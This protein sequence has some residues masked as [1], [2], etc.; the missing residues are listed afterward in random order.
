M[1]IGIIVQA[2]MGST[3]L[4][5]KVLKKV[6]DKTILNHVIQRLKQCK[7]ADEIIVA[8]TVLNRDDA[9]EKEAIL[10]GARV[11]RGSESDV[12]ERYYMAAKANALDAVIRVTSDCPLIDPQILDEMISYYTKHEFEIVTNVGNEISNRTYPR[13]LDVEIFSFKS[14]EKAYYHADEDYHREHVT[15][16]LYEETEKVYFFKN[17]V[18]YSN[19]RWTVDTEE[20][21]YL[22]TKIYDALY[23]G[24]HN[25]YL[26][27]II[28]LFER[29]PELNA[30]NA[31]IEQ[32][33]IK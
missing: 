1:K 22:I 5:G 32:K 33:K 17:P 26:K 9:I 31:H 28:S 21:F 27:D 2:R 18:D 8:T 3:R 7:N 6:G 30:I 24:E 12:L 14:L 20:D 4:S 11:F 16:Y 25:F 29:Q 15:P 23:K 19:Y 10:S 13:G